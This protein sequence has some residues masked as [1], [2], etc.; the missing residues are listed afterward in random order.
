[1]GA[2]TPGPLP[3]RLVLQGEVAFSPE[4]AQA[5]VHLVVTVVLAQA[6]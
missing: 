6:A 5:A 2:R 4:V 3:Q 1:M